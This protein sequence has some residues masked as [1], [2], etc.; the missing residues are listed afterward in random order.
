[1]YY[2]K[3]RGNEKLGKQVVVFNRP[4]GTTCPPNCPLLEHG[5]YAEFTEHRFTQ[6]RLVGE[7]NLNATSQELLA[8]L[9]FAVSK[10]KAVRVHE[11]GDF[12]LDG[13]IDRK[14]LRAWQR[15]IKSVKKLPHI[16]AFTHVYLKS[17][18]NLKDVNVY[19]SVHNEGDVKKAKQ[20]GFTLFAYLLPD[21][22]KKGG[23]R[24]FPKFVNLPVIGKTLVCPEQRLG[25]KRITCDA[26]RWC[27]EGKGNVA[28]LKS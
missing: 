9:E 3:R 12:L 27:V 23:S 17:L 4:V 13:K 18:A 21:R 19:A 8:M 11:R 14:Y 1:M 7:N 24:D 25:R 6:A 26:C 15:A 10:N 28:F 16:W 20:K 2:D 22:K 5:C